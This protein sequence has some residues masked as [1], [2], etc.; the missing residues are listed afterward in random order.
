MMQGNTLHHPSSSNRVRL[1]A[2]LLAFGSVSG[3]LI[4]CGSN[5]DSNTEKI[6]SEVSYWN[7]VVPIFEQSCLQC[8]QQGGIAP[9]RL[10]TFEEASKWAPQIAD[11]TREGTMPPW[12]ATNDGSCGKFTN[13]NELS[14]KQIE[15]LGA[16]D[17]QGAPEGERDGREIEV[18]ELPGIDSP[19][20][21][22]TPSIV[23][24]IQGGDLAEF[25][26]YRCFPIAALPATARMKKP[27]K[28][29]C[30]WMKKALLLHL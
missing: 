2:Y 21:Y 8:H 24:E 27:G 14:A 13:T 11:A 5:D 10:D 30:A 1:R 25:D 3:L 29:I 4:G 23:P 17:D 28:P 26:E 15:L 9:F 19:V 12:Y 7:D 22:Q 6:Q 16:W 20:E 18:P